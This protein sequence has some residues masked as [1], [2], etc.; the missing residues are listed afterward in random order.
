MSDFTRSIFRSER[1]CQ[2]LNA[3]F[4]VPTP[5]SSGFALCFNVVSEAVDTWGGGVW[6]ICCVVPEGE[7]VWMEQWVGSKWG[8]EIKDDGNQAR[9]KCFISF[10]AS[11]VFPTEGKGFGVRAVAPIP[12]GAFVCCYIGEVLSV[13]EYRPGSVAWRR[14][15]LL[16]NPKHGMYLGRRVTTEEVREDDRDGEKATAFLTAR[17]SWK[18]KQRYFQKEKQGN[19]HPTPCLPTTQSMTPLVSVR[20]VK[21]LNSFSGYNSHKIVLRFVH[22]SCGGCISCL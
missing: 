19:F 21:N 3:P 12:Q 8:V 10:N 11:Q 22:F 14:W 9:I 6:S 2:S 17:K 1:W 18:T 5:H 16:R 15:P 13:A 7:S 20:A 4:L